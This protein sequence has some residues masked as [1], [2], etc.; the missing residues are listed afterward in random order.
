VP[1]A[2]AH[3]GEI[4]PGAP[5][6]LDDARHATSLIDHAAP[7]VVPQC[8]DNAGMPAAL[9]RHSLGRGNPVITVTDY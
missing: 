5:R 4:E 2:A 8:R 1:D 9:E 3:A 7:R 6:R